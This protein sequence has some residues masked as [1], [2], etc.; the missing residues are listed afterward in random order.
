MARNIY[1]RSILK[2]YDTTEFFQQLGL[3]SG[4]LEVHNF[5]NMETSIAY[6]DTDGKFELSISTIFDYEAG[7]N[8]Y[9]AFIVQNEQDD[10]DLSLRHSENGAIQNF[11]DSHIDEW[12]RP[13]LYFNTIRWMYNKHLLPSKPV[14]SWSIDKVNWHNLYDMW[15]NAIS[16]ENTRSF[17]LADLTQLVENSMFEPLPFEILNEA[18]ALTHSAPRVALIVAA[19]A[20]EIGVKQ[21]IKYKNPEV[22]WILDNI[23][24]P[25]VV[26]LLTELVIKLEPNLTFSQATISELKTLVSARNTAIHLGTFDDTAKNAAKMGQMIFSQISL[27]SDILYYLAYYTGHQW[28]RIGDQISQQRITGNLRN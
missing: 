12:E 21:F 4:F 24:S 11:I 10:S 6:T 9:Q 28:I 2:Y 22:E 1:I 17:N 8:A 3:E 7:N 15:I 16:V 13:A 5:R 18:K 27:V 14:Q 25:P 26:K 23:Q 19:M 20:L